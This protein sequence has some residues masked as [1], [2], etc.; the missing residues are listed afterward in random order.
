MRAPIRPTRLHQQRDIAVP[1]ASRRGASFI[2]VVLG[3]ALLG[4]VAGTLTLTVGAIGGSF[5]RQQDRLGAAEIASRLLLMRADDEDSLPGSNAQISFGTRNFR[6]TMEERGVQVTLSEPAQEATSDGTSG[7]STLDLSRRL[8]AVS[9]TTWLS[10]DSGGSATFNEN[11]PH[12]TLTRLIDP[13]SFTTSDS[14]E[15]RLET[16]EDIEDFMSNVI[17]SMSTGDLPINTGG[18]GGSGGTTQQRSPQRGTP[19]TEGSGG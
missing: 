3:V 4:M 1:P 7:G 15:A 10:E 6:W 17:G 18:G 5:Q 12:Y 8:V 2:E 9:V 19:S 14:A 11:V 16:Q 13:I